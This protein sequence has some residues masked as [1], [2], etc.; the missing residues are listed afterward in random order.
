MTFEWQS[1]SVRWCVPLAQNPHFLLF[2]VDIPQIIVQ[3]APGEGKYIAACQA[4]QAMFKPASKEDPSSVRGCFQ[5]IY[6]AN[7]EGCKSKD[8]IDNK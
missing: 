6:T 8:A 1:C 7:L 4:G 2:L 3:G 5:A